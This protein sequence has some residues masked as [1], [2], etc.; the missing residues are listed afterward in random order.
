MMMMMILLNTTV[1]KI[2]EVND[3]DTKFPK[4][5]YWDRVNMMMMM[6]MTIQYSKRML[7]GMQ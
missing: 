3:G 2:E 7:T 1:L 4:Y 5:L 6:A